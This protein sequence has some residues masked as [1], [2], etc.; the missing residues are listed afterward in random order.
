[1]T[2]NLRHGEKGLQGRVAEGAGDR[3][4]GIDIISSSILFIHI[5]IERGWK[6]GSFY[7]VI[8]G[9]ELTV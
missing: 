6:E 1:M 5:Y 4:G 8:D 9:L 3:K 2:I 7:I